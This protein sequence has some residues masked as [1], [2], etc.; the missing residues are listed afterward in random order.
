[1][2][3]LT[4]GKGS[5]ALSPEEISDLLITPVYNGSTIGQ[6]SQL[7]QVQGSSLRIPKVTDGDNAGW[8]AE[9][10]EINVSEADVDEIECH[11]KNLSALSFVSNVMVQDSMKE[12]GGILSLVGDALVRDLIRKL[13]AAAFGATTANGPAG[14][15]SVTGYHEIEDSLFLNGDKI[16]DAIYAIRASGGNADRIVTTPQVAAVLAKQKVSLNS[17]Q[18]LYGPDAS[19]PLA[20]TISGVPVI[21][22]AAVKADTVYVVDSTRIVLAVRGGDDPTIDVDGSV[23]FTSARTCVRCTLRADIAFVDPTTIAVI[24][25][26]PDIYTM[27]VDDELGG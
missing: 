17:N 2:S 12:H 15:Q 22:S 25:V 23:A 6:I 8:V 27:G 7:V 10:A 14:I 24:P 21:A 5:G 26:N 11:F 20:Q 4:T 3:I 1:M 13:D 18:P 16:V 9:G 19:G